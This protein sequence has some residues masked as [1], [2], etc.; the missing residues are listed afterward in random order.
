MIDERR[1]L[2]S[3]GEEFNDLFSRL[4]AAND[5][6]QDAKRS[7]S[8]QEIFGEMFLLL[9]AGHET[10]AHAVSEALIGIRRAKTE[11]QASQKTPVESATLA[12]PA[13]LAEAADDLKAVGRIATLDLVEADEV[14]VSDVVLAEES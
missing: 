5:S 6:E 10:S 4:L 9:L 1:K 14:A 13:I 8:T 2:M 3:E 12:G 7:L 11:A